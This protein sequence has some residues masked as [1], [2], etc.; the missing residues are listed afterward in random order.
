[1]TMSV[2]KDQCADC[3]SHVPQST[4]SIHQ[5]KSGSK[6]HA[7]AIPYYYEGLTEQYKMG[8]L[9]GGNML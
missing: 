9:S 4:T 6:V 2:F 7:V 1:M 8:A 3:L 5:A